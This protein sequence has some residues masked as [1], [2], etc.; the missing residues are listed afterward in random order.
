[1]IVKNEADILKRCLETVFDIMDEI[2][3]VDTGS[4]DSTKEIAAL[5]TDKIFDF[6]WI[7]DFSA[8]RNFA[9]SKASCEYIYSADADE[10]IDEINRQR[11]KDLKQILNGEAELVQMYYVNQ[12]KF[13]TVY[14]FDREY[15]PKLFKRNRIFTWIDPIHETIRLEPVI[16]DSEIEIIHEPKASHAA[17]D[18]AIFRGM[19]APNAPLGLPKRLNNL[20]ARELFMVG[21][22]NDFLEA[23][24]YF[25]WVASDNASSLEEIKEAACVVARASRLRGD[26]VKFFKFAL[27]DIGS[28]GSSEICY[29]L[30]EFYRSQDDLTEAVIWFFNAAFETSSIIDIKTSGILP[31]TALFECYETLN[32]KDEAAKY[33]KLASEWKAEK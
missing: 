29:E 23:E 7:D 19:T 22:K 9:F 26:A 30:G 14:N 18:L 21:E 15:R 24:A 32:I 17:R 16:F 4:T 27:K 33:K 5:Y 20:Y 1:M 31:L 10:V 28:E 13:G 25:E 2:I 8:A 6:E 3:I 12:L 11:F